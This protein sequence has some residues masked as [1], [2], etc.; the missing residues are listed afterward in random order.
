MSGKM[1][2]DEIAKRVTRGTT[3]RWTK[4]QVLFNDGKFAV[5]KWPG[6]S[7]EKVSPWVKQY[8]ID[9]LVEG[10]RYPDGETVWSS[11]QDGRLTAKRVRELIKSLKLDL[12]GIQKKQPTTVVHS[13]YQARKQKPVKQRQITLETRAVKVVL[14]I[15]GAIPSNWEEIVSRTALVGAVVDKISPWYIVLEYSTVTDCM[16][17]IS[18]DREA[19][20]DAMEKA[21]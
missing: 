3:T 17:F 8:S 9:K 20:M 1:T 15:V 5:V 7:R 14:K 19:L 13:R 10:S 6:D 12:D 11:D 16:E 2:N 18:S 4:V 21:I